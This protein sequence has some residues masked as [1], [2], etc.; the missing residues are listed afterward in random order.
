MRIVLIPYAI[1]AIAFFN[2][3]NPLYGQK[4]T[5]K[6]EVSMDQPTTHIFH[7]TMN[8]TGF[9]GDSIDV[10]MP[11]WSPGYYQRLD[12]ANNVENFQVTDASQNTTGWRKMP[13]NAW[14]VNNTVSSFVINYDVKTTRPFVG[15]PYLDE[16]RGYILPA[17]VFLYPAGEI[18]HAVTV[19]I[20][21]YSVWNNVATGLDSVFGKRFVYV[22]PDYDILYDSPILVGNLE[23]FPPFFVKGIPHRFIA[24]KPGEFDKVSFMNDLKKIVETATTL[25]GD[26]PYKH[27]TFIGIGPGAGGI[28]HLNSTTVSFDGSGQNSPQN[29]LKTYFFL[30]HEYFHHYNVKRIRPIE[31]G[32]FDYDNGSRTKMLWVSEGLSVYYEEMIVKRAGLCSEDE[33]FNAFRSNILAYEDKPGRL[34]Q[35]LT[36]ASYETWSDGPF[37]RTGDEVNKTISYYDKGPAVGMLLDFKIRHETKNKK[38]L[39][40][41][42]RTL[43]KEFYQQKKRGFTEEEFRQVCEKIAGT[44][45]S[46]VF[47]YVSTTKEVD[48]KKYLQYAGLD[49]DTVSKE[50]TGGWLGISARERKDSV[51]IANVDWNSPAW[52][53]GLR[54]RN[55]IVEID[56]A[57]PNAKAIE[58]VLKNKLPDD[59]IDVTVMQGNEKKKIGIVLGKKMEAPFTISRM[60]G[61]DK[62][63]RAILEGWLSGSKGLKN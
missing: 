9:K 10:K 12:F 18:N 45:L 40:D 23:E 63:Q 29:R 52:N 55:L 26:I 58:P 5:I 50:I 39:D 59:K 1:I 15:T 33:L 42:M 4:S 2:P 24:Y 13:G 34:Y 22:A 3:F 19:A 47:D 28:E 61:A 7:V 46:D 27:Y 49:I 16:G 21:P 43:Y 60:P 20:K 37:G 56:G 62:V 35:S 31:L 38:S 36:Q 14:R 51:F 25:I 30:A 11:V 32:P 6:F 8:C 53:A 48:Y 41:V 54:Q 44:S 17:G 57:R